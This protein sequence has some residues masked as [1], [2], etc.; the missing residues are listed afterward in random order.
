MS[1]V[2]TFIAGMGLWTLLEYLLHRFVFH[3]RMLGKAA[4][5]EHLQ[6]HA[7]VDWFSPWSSKLGLAA[8]VLPAVTLVAL[9]VAGAAH[10]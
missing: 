9:P 1:L 5:A 7:R 2:W 8:V 3:D 10:A 6:H 4:A